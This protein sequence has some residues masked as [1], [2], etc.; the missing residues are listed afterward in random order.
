VCA[1]RFRGFD[2]LF[3]IGLLTYVLMTFIG[4]QG[5]EAAKAIGAHE[6]ISKLPMAMIMM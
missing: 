2:F 3:S 6:F 5:I 1:D 4:E